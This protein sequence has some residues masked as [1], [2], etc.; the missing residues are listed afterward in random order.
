MIRFLSVALLTLTTSS[1]LAD[2]YV[3]GNLKGK[4]F[5]AAE[6]WQLGDDGLSN[7][8]FIIEIYGQTAK[9]S[10]NDMNCRP[11]LPNGVICKS[12]KG[13]LSALETWTVYPEDNT[14]IFTKVRSGLGFFD[15]AMMFKGDILKRC[16]ND[17][18]IN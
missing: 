4:G 8:Q 15:G 5:R 17:A 6:N 11:G 13:G 1:A 9:V 2:C 14:V 3:V 16:G 12:S 10:P 7:Q 18:L